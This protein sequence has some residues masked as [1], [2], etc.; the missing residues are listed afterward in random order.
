M[1]SI[2]ELEQE[3]AQSTRHIVEARARMT[4]QF[5]IMRRLEADG[6]DTARAKTLYRALEDGLEAMLTRREH[7]LREWS[8]A[9]ERSL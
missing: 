3:L 9:G 7:I 4:R 5:E 8:E 6:H 2:A 1:V